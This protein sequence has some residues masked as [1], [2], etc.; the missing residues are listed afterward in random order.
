MEASPLENFEDVSDEVEV[1]VEAAGSDP[2][3][4]AEDDGI[5]GN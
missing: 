3:P 5:G 4:G 2:C 1:A